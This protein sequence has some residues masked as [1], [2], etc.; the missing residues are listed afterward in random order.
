MPVLYYLSSHIMPAWTSFRI[1]ENR[2]ATKASGAVVVIYNQCEYKLKDQSLCSSNPWLQYTV[3]PFSPHISEWERENWIKCA[4][5]HKLALIYSLSQFFATF[6]PHGLSPCPYA[7]FITLVG[8]GIT[9]NPHCIMWYTC[10]RT[11]SNTFS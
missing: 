9:T 5:L 8:S 6:P 1:H 10:I 3:A 4:D 11:H 7:R 2:S